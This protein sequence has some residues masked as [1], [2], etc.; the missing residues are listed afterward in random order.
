LKRDD[1]ALAA[2]RDALK[3]DDKDLP[4]RQYIAKIYLKRGEVDQAQPEL[5][6]IVAN[7][8]RGTL[9]PWAKSQLE[10]IQKLKDSSAK[11]AA[12]A[13]AGQMS[14]Q[15]FLKSQGAQLFMEA[16]YEDALKEFETLAAQAPRDL[17]VLRYR[18]LALDRLGRQDEAI[19]LLEEGLTAFP[20]SVA[21]HYFLAQTYLHKRD[22]GAAKKE[23]QWVAERDETGAYKPRADAELKEV[24]Q[25]LEL[26]RRA[27]PKPWSVNGSA[28]VEWVSNPASNTR[29]A[30]LQTSVT[31]SAWKFSNSAGA[32]YDFLK[33]GAL[34]LKGTYS[35]SHALYSDSFSNLNTVSN[36]W[37]ANG[38]YIKMLRGKPFI[39]Q[40]G[41]TTA[42]TILRT[43]FYSVSFTESLSFI[44]SLKDWYRITLSDRWTFSQ[45]ASDGS[46]PDSTGR[47]GF[48]NVVGVT[49]NFYLNK[50]KNLSFLL[51]FDYGR[52]DTQGINYVKNELTYRTGMHFPMVWKWEGD[53]SFKFKDSQYPKYGFPIT[54]PGRRDR[55]YALGITLSRPLW[56]YFTLSTS[57]NYTDNNSR[58]DNFTYRNHALGA[59][60]SFYY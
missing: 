44:Y 13:R 45:Y 8:S 21:L 43:T 52:D 3:L 56:R 55:Q 1:E 7:D 57:Y 15:D 11:A 26:L 33:K 50:K 46:A 14:P 35:Y 39:A 29:V 25:I 30:A 20:G 51:G 16:K 17:L 12:A 2:F 60:L 54:T 6:F 23:Y 28:G 38:T 4:S 5:E 19:K 10:S 27:K 47:D 58:D 37:G 31:N 42:H 24:E 18:A 36:S 41:H 32:S 22:Y 9:A 53:I 48:G 40:L 49:N 34:T 59:T